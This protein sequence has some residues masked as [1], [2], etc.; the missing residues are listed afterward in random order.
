MNP[1]ARSFNLQEA[2][3]YLDF[4][5]QFTPQY[6][7]SFIEYMRLCMLESGSTRQLDDLRHLC[8]NADPNYGALWCHCKKE[9]LDDAGQVLDYACAMLQEELQSMSAIY[10]QALLR[11]KQGTTMLGGPDAPPAKLFGRPSVHLGRIAAWPCALCRLPLQQ[12]TAVQLSCSHVFHESCALD[13]SINQ[14]V[15]PCSSETSRACPACQEPWCVTE[16]FLPE[17]GAVAGSLSASKPTASRR[18]SLARGLSIRSIDLSQSSLGDCID[19]LGT[20]MLDMFS[21]KTVM[22]S[23]QTGVGSVKLDQSPQEGWLEAEGVVPED[24]ATGIVEL[25]RWYRRVS[26]EPRTRTC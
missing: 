11:S 10:T 16:L 23:A 1:L 3:R 24:F 12:Q 4:A 5:V 8:A 2:R 17:E 26:L 13:F 19:E 9:A 14:T 20:D 15:A 25:N 18:P 6:G 7:D 22:V 21:T